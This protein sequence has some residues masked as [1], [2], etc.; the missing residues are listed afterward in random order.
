MKRF[1]LFTSLF[2][3][4]ALAAV[5]TSIYDLPLKTITG[6]DVT[7]SD[8][9]GKTLLIVNVASKCGL[10]KQ[11]AGLE[12]LY[13][14][15]SDQGLVVLGFPCNQFGGQEPGTNEEIVAFCSSKFNV[16]FPLFDKI[17]VN[18]KNRAPLYDLLAGEGSPFPGKI[19]WNFSKF[20]IGP[21]GTLLQRFAPRVAPDSPE[22][23]AAI[24]AALPA[25]SSAQG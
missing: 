6:S 16:T 15:Y 9:K 12:A 2:C 14:K 24:E 19:K 21:D 22:M 1:I 8:Y 18:G 3:L 10:T 25:K 4:Q 5:A 23:I 11:Y 20:L 7:L 13:Q 17:D